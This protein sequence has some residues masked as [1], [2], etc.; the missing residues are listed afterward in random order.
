VI[1]AVVAVIFWAAA[2]HKSIIYPYYFGIWLRAN[3]KTGTILWTTLGSLLSAATL[4]LLN[5]L[6][7]L[8]NKQVSERKGATL[9]TIE[10]MT[11]HDRYPTMSFLT[12]YC[13]A[14][15]KLLNHTFILDFHRTKLSLFSLLFWG[16]ALY[17]ST[18]YTTLLT[19]TNI[20]VVEQIYG[21][22]LDFTS[23]EFW[24]W[25]KCH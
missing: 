21:S 25:V 10:G 17:L 12:K 3:P 9:S 6:L 15:G 1:L 24:S 2:A 22:E 13:V 5:G 23:R 7:L 19:P 20:L 8:M 18:A 16:V 11:D 14:W 4:Y